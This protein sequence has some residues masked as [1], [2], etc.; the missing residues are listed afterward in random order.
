[1]QMRGG[2]AGLV[3]G[4]SISNAVVPG[5]AAD[6]KKNGRHRHAVTQPYRKMD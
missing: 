1:M 6:E 4:D 3:M 2:A 5:V